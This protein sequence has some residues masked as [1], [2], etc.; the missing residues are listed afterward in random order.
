MEKQISELKLSKTEHSK[1]DLEALAESIK[2]VG[3]LE[4]VVIDDENYVVSGNRRVMAAKLAGLKSVPVT[5][6]KAVSETEA[7]IAEIDSNLMI[8]PVGRPE[9]DKLLARR[10]RLFEEQHPEAKQYAAGAAK[11]KGFA[12]V[13]AKRLGVSK[14][15]IEKAVT[16]FEKASP[17]VLEAREKDGLSPSKVSEL[18]K[19]KPEAQEKILPY[20]GPRPVGQVREA[21]KLVQDKGVVA[22]MK[23]LER[24]PTP[25]K[26]TQI[27]GHAEKLAILLLDVSRDE[28]SSP[29]VPHLLSK[30]H[31][32]EL[33]IIKFSAQATKAAVSRPRQLSA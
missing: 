4:P 20:V 18:V 11:V 12:A 32:L 3:I 17:K 13:A 6:L 22:A 15:T 23:F 16:R 1:K 5:R 33:A 29:F 30:L 28:L 19:L 7:E 8:V 10:K 31:K 26:L 21:V 25:G 2:A 9:Y 24:E 14:R 27:D